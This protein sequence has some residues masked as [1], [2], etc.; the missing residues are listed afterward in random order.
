MKKYLLYA[1]GLFCFNC[2]IQ[3]DGDTRLVANGQLLDR[4]ANPIANHDI[5]IWAYTHYNG[6][7]GNSSDLISLTKT[8]NLGEFE[9]VFPQA[10]GNISYEIKALDNTYTYQNKTVSNIKTFNFVDYTFSSTNLF[11]LIETDDIM[12]LT[13]LLNHVNTDNQIID[14]SIDGILANN[15]VYVNPQVEPEPYY[16]D[17]YYETV[18]KNQS[19]IINYD[20]RNNST[21][22]VSSLQETLDVSD[23]DIYEYTLNY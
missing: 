11:N 22:T 13:I 21:Q 15:Y 20:V 9:M 5:E 17:S 7:Y 18:A 19:L 10:K 12:Q 4:N 14:I 2:T 23:E 1:L 8:N 6:S 16:Y 3:Y